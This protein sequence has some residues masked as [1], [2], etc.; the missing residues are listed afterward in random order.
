MELRTDMVFYQIKRKFKNAFGSFSHNCTVERPIFPDTEAKN[1]KHIVVVGTDD[2]VQFV[3]RK[4]YPLVLFAGI[5]ED[6][7]KNVT[8]NYIVLPGTTSVSHAFNEL[9]DIFDSFERWHEELEDAVNQY[10]SYNAILNSCEPFVDDPIALLDNQFQ[11]ICY[12]KRLAHQKKFDRYV[13]NSAYLPLE[14]INYLNS[15]P[16][17]KKLEQR[18]DVFQY[19]AVENLLHKNIFYRG[20]YIARLAIPHSEEEYVNRF[21]ICILEILA[22]YIERLHNQFGTFRRLEKKDSLLKE[23]LLALLDRKFTNMRELDHLLAEKDFR[24]TDHYYLIRFTSGFTNN[25]ENTAQALAN[26]LEMLIPGSVSLLYKGNTLT[27]I[28]AS[29]YERSGETSLMQKLAYY[30][31]DSLLQAGI[32]RSFSN[33][34]A[35]DAAYRQSGIAFELG[36]L[37]DSSSW[38]FRFDDYAFI[39]L[40]Q[41]GSHAFLPEQICHPA[42]MQLIVYDQEHNTALNETLRTFLSLQCNA[43]ECARRLF[44]NRSSLLKRLERIEKITEIHMDNLEERVYLELSYMILEQEKGE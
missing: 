24:K 26:H 35:L 17:F 7:I 29:F 14:D 43:S 32:S 34:T 10:F 3:A 38:Y 19:V 22:K 44:I 36:T 18:K 20:E 27:L 42:I 21:Y 41:Q 12:T 39:Y 37:R 5:S 30:L 15:L 31:R 28:N 4:E 9:T 33:L 6:Q 11:Y 2:F 40:L 25:N 8:G 13:C 1:K 23:H 16:D